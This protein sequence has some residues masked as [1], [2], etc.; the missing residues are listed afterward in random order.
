MRIVVIFKLRNCWY[1]SKCHA[2]YVDRNCGCSEQI[3]HNTCT[4]TV[5]TSASHIKHKVAKVFS[6]VPSSVSQQIWLITRQEVGRGREL[7]WEEEGWRGWRRVTR[8]KQWHQR[9]CRWAV[10]GSPSTTCY[11]SWLLLTRTAMLLNKISLQCSKWEIFHH[12]KFGHR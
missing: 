3:A 10:Y 5:K 1:I 2:Q 6:T 7:M 4:G 8:G 9:H 11:I 12:K